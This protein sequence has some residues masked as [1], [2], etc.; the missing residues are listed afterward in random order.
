[1]TGFIRRSQKAGLMFLN[2]EF[3]RRFFSLRRHPWGAIA[4]CALLGFGCPA[5]Y[6]LGK[7]IPH[8]RFHDE[9]SYLFAADTFAH[10]R[11]TNPTPVFPEFFE[12]EHVLVAPTCM[13]KYPPGQGLVMA[14]GQVLFGHPVWGVWLS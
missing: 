3:A 8:P 1:M 13:S 4:L 11:L 6:G 10:G 7:R 12:A 2:S 14:A 5:L 9:Y